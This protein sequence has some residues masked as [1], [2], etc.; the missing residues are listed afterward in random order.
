MK[1]K[2]SL[3]EWASLA[4]VIGTLGV[5]ISLIFLVISIN[6]NSAEA[7]AASTQGFTDS[8]LA[9]ETMVAADA[10][11]SKIIVAGRKPTARLSE[12]EQFRYDAYVVAML[13]NWDGLQGR[14]VDGLM[15]VENLLT[16]DAYFSLWAERNV[17]SATWDR[18]KWQFAGTIIP[19]ME[20]AIAHKQRASDQQ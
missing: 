4:E 8:V 9:I 10:E 12:V 20:R 17:S 16:W 15:E 13:D 6:K 1:R 2:L 11:W 18:I 7:T 3:S 19:K 5:I 14:F